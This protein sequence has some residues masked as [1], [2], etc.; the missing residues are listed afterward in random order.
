MAHEQLSQS[1]ICQGHKT[2]STNG[3]KDHHSVPARSS[4]DSES[5]LFNLASKKVWNK[6]TDVGEVSDHC[7][8][9]FPSPNKH[10]QNSINYLCQQTLAYIE[11]P[12]SFKWTQWQCL[13][14]KFN[15][16]LMQPEILFKSV[17]FSRSTAWPADNF[18]VSDCSRAVWKEPLRTAA[19][20]TKASMD[21][22]TAWPCSVSQDERSNNHAKCWKS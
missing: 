3:F 19:N 11:A 22:L 4:T 15:Q 21:G 17:C 10:E 18:T 14:F 16:F 2:K 6:A 20:A 1:L 9:I 13:V 5:T 8:E 7:S 12:Q